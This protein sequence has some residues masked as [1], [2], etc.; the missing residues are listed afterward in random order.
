MSNTEHSLN[1]LVWIIVI[2]LVVMMIV[3]LVIVK[4]DDNEDEEV[5]RRNNRTMAIWTFIFAGII[6][7]CILAW[8]K[9][10]IKIDGLDGKKSGNS[11]NDIGQSSR[12]ITEPNLRSNN[13]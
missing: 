10:W 13:K 11:I 9:G 8:S 7:L 4:G 1:N 6:V 12:G 3:V 5:Q 2:A